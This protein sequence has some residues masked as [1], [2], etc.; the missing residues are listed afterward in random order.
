MKWSLVWS[1][2]GVR[3]EFGL[4]WSRQSV[5]RVI[6]GIGSKDGTTTLGSLLG[7]L[8]NV[9][10]L[11]LEPLWGF[12]SFFEAFSPKGSKR[13]QKKGPKRTSIETAKGSKKGSKKRDF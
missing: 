12:G 7:L 9:E 11:L 1:G 8:R 2:V 5:K 13:A 6:W 4:E 3:E 10:L